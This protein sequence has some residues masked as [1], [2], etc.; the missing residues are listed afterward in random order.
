[1]TGVTCGKGHHG[2]MR[3]LYVV[4]DVHGY[5]DDLARGLGE[6]GLVD[7]EGRWAGAD[8]ELWVLGDLLDRGPD[9]IGALDL[10][11][12]LQQ[13][14][15]SQVH[16]LMGNHEVLALGRHRFPRSRFAES[17]RINGGRTRDQEALT[18]GH[19]SWLAS[20]PVMARVGD[21]LLVHSD[22][23]R[24]LRWGSHVDE[25]NAAVRAALAD[26]RDLAAHWEL[27]AGLT[28]RY[29]FTADGG[30]AAARM[31]LARYGGE[32][33]VHGHS[34]IASLTGTASH[35]VDRPLLYADRLALD[36]DGGRYD[37]GPLLVV[38]LA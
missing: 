11:M 14:A 13:Q 18:P 31:M 36:I 33:V 35:E 9:G 37:G 8:D 34:V 20:L 2:D 28:G 4:S 24:Y 10:V 22:T 25:V 26:E 21:Y 17:W 23:T 7:A 5:R 6:V 32:V 30:T 38:R 3:S 15:P 12:S 16:V 19:L 29:A 1:M 27:W